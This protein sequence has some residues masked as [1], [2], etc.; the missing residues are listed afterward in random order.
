M[1]LNGRGTEEGAR[2]PFGGYLYSSRKPT[3]T[4]FQA[5]GKRP[6]ILV[7]EP[8]DLS[9]QGKV[10]TRPFGLDRSGGIQG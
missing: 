3:P 4:V 1:G 6:E 10:Q 9:S 8:C 5:T 7:I 2:L